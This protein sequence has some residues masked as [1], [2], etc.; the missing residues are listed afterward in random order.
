MVMDLFLYRISIKRLG[1]CVVGPSAKF[2]LRAMIMWPPDLKLSDI[3]TIKSDRKETKCLLMYFKKYK[4]VR[5]LKKNCLWRRMDIWEVD[6]IAVEFYYNWNSESH[7]HGLET[8]VTF[9]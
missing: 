2:L 7:S 6:E 3:V 9:L 5:N 8:S 1:S 4:N